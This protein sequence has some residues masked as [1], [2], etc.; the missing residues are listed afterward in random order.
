MV[1]TAQ[2]AGIPIQ[3]TLTYR[4]KNLQDTLYA[5]GRTAGGIIVTNAKGL[6]SYHN[7]GLAFDV[8]FNGPVPYPSKEDPKWKQLADLATPLG[9]IWG[10]TFGDVDHFEF[11]QGF[12]WNILETYFS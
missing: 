9:L 12:T 7:Y 10:G 11:H 5:K 8:C 4:T 3:I 2:S 1:A 6:Q